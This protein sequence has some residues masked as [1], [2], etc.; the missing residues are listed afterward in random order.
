MRKEREPEVSALQRKKAEI[1]KHLSPEILTIYKELKAQNVPR[2]FVPLE[3]PNRCGG[4]RMDLPV[5]KLSAL[6]EKGYIRCE[7]C[8]RIIYKQ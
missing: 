4:C 5:G 3:E 6:S 1:E 8:H 2:P 7:N